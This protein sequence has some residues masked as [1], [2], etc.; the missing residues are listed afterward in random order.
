MEKTWNFYE[1]YKGQTNIPESY[2]A[3]SGLI[4]QDDQL[5]PNLL[6]W[7]LRSAPKRRRHTGSS[8]PHKYRRNPKGG[9][10]PPA[11]LLSS[12]CDYNK[13]NISCKR[14]PIHLVLLSWQNLQCAHWSAV[15]RYSREGALRG[16]SEHVENCSQ[17]ICSTHT[18][19]TV[20]PVTLWH[21]EL[22][23]T[24]TSFQAFS[25]YTK[26]TTSSTPFSPRE[27]AD[28]E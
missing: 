25:R 16:R 3:I 9:G 18:D 26:H 22:T 17:C 23:E 24:I 21:S 7:T 28:G 11:E 20:V 5:K 10:E 8:L 2:F 15:D 27:R 12:G 13:Q 4:L 19:P 14:P 6:T 1:H